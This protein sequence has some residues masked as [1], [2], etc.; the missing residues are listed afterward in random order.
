M[1]CVRFLWGCP[2]TA[3][4]RHASPLPRIFLDSLTQLVL[5]AAAGEAAS[6]RRLGRRALAWGALAGTLPDLDVLAAPFLSEPEALRFHRSLTHSLFFAF[7]AAPLLGW[8]T[9]R[10]HRRFRWGGEAAAEVRPWVW[11]WFWALWTHP[12]LDAFTVYGTQLLW[13]FS[14]HPFAISS[15]FIIDLAY[16][17][18]LIVACVVAWRAKDDAGRRLRSVTIGLALSSAYLVWG[19]AVQAYVER[20][21]AATLAEMDGGPERRVLVA[22]APLSSVLWTV[23]VETRSA[24]VEASAGGAGAA[25]VGAAAVGET[26]PQFLAG[27]VSLFDARP[28]RVVFQPIEARHDRMAGA[29]G[30]GAET[31]RW[32]S[33]GWHA[34][35]P[36]SALDPAAG[37]SLD[38]CDLR[39]GRTDGFDTRGDA[40]CIFTFRMPPDGATF[41][42][43][44]PSFDVGT[45]LPAL[46]HRTTGHPP[47]W[48][49]SP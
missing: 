1:P 18:P 42:Q 41:R 7:V 45:A 43:F 11:L 36:A 5:G 30:E 32:F 21:T 44:Q 25:P 20:V 46:W 4:A 49:M 29:T 33:Q 38:V 6:G 34:V 24:P 2:C 8:L 23:L 19:V 40:P 9:A 26:G 3:L 31:V 48:A 28:H 35:R 15:V 47:A 27:T 16:T 37:D 17:V 14:N 39:F 10:L 22:P 12:M 13:P